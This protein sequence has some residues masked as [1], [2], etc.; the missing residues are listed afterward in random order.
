MHSDRYGFPKGKI[1]EKEDP[2]ECAVREVLE[3]TGLNIGKYILNPQVK[4]SINRHSKPVELFVAAGVPDTLP[5][6]PQF[7]GEIEEISWMPISNLPLFSS[8]SSYLIF[9]FEA[10]D[11]ALK[12]SKWFSSKRNSIIPAHLPPITPVNKL[13]SYLFVDE[14]G[15]NA[16]E[17][18]NSEIKLRESEAQS[19]RS[20]ST[21]NKSLHQKQ[22][23][24]LKKDELTLFEL[25]S[26]AATA[27][28]AKTS[29][30]TSQGRALS[31]PASSSL[32]SF[33]AQKTASSA[34]SSVA[35]SA[36][37]STSSSLMH[38]ST[39]TES[40]KSKTKHLS[41]S[42]SA[43][44]QILTESH[45]AANNSTGELSDGPSLITAKANALLSFLNASAKSSPNAQ[46]EV[47]EQEKRMNLKGSMPSEKTKDE[48]FS[49]INS[50]SSD[51]SSHTASVSHTLLTSTEKVTTATKATKS[52]SSAE[53]AQKQRNNSP[54]SSVA[55]SLSIS[56]TTAAS[57]QTDPQNQLS[58][59]STAEPKIASK[60]KNASK[61]NVSAV[62]T[63]VASAAS[64]TAGN[65]ITE[66]QSI[67]QKLSSIS[68]S[69]STASSK[70]NNSSANATEASSSSLLSLLHIE[71][72]EN[73]A[74]QVELAKLEANSL[75]HLKALTKETT[76]AKANQK[77]VKDSNKMKNPLAKAEAAASITP[78]AANAAHPKNTSEMINVLDLLRLS[79]SQQAEG[80]SESA[81][82]SR[83]AAVSATGL[84]IP[85]KDVKDQQ[86]EKEAK[87]AL[88]I[89]P[90]SSTSSVP[91]AAQLQQQKIQPQKKGH[92]QSQ[93]Q[94]LPQSST[95]DA[96][97]VPVPEP[98]PKRLIQPVRTQT[99]AESTQ[100][101]LM[102]VNKFK[103]NIGISNE[104]TNSP[105]STSDSRQIAQMAPQNVDTPQK[106][107]QN[108][109]KQSQKGSKTQKE[110]HLQNSFSYKPVK[111]LS[112]ADLVKDFLLSRSPSYS[113][114]LPSF[115]P[116]KRKANPKSFSD[117]YE[118]IK[119]SSLVKSSLPLPSFL[120][121][122]EP[123]NIPVPMISTHQM[124]RVVIPPLRKYTEQFCSTQFLL[125]SSQRS[126]SIN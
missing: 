78:S 26:Q 119:K 84:K 43:G 11:L 107:Q 21:I 68:T 126:A 76:I 33:S 77:S 105:I 87:L 69:S 51:H 125:N 123:I 67:V 124:E 39:P 50:S 122:V 60:T 115:T 34:S 54:L 92:M 81:D 40:D 114:S 83:T 97:R 42:A 85:Q 113:F 24:D 112:A 44:K 31:T 95:A 32:L 70:P 12:F 111:R 23:D 13:S 56:F 59:S 99:A 53:D 72:Q 109:T 74:N 80:N 104:T 14:A 100:K 25:L 90:P 7:E 10:S 30:Q 121:P 63:S 64:Q 75:S 66:K 49:G 57:H 46:K 15:K 28:Q 61:T 18:R 120:L 98:R 117:F 106:K 35:A 89:Q 94:S 37:S 58:S 27:K 55:S 93:P 88:S 62:V 108:N 20:K 9:T 79:L 6:A 102:D 8:D 36:S 110:N 4:F 3:E 38:S 2:L 73:H 29:T 41:S 19:N 47:K 86:I 5:V 45:R 17:K 1:E 65:A 52:S 96:S 101:K 48:P 22:N 103:L 16:K 82:K 71:E 91:S 118:R 116:P